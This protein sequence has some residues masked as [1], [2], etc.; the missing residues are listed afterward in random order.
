MISALAMHAA[1]ALHT[2]AAQQPPPPAPPPDSAIGAPA[3]PLA[4][5]AR[6][7]PATPPPTALPASILDVAAA[8]VAQP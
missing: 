7:P 3:P 6:A 5:L 4:G 1:H 2:A 8:L